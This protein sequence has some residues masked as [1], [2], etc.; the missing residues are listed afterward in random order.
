MLKPYK[1]P[2]YLKK[3]ELEKGA[4]YVCDARNFVEGTWDGEAFVYTRFKFG[5]EFLDTEQHWDDGAPHGTV[6]PFEKIIKK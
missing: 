2:T 4:T 6:K 5:D 3:E 1:E